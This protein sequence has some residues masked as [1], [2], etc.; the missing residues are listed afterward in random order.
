MD[1]FFKQN[2]RALKSIVV[3]PI[4][5]LH[6]VTAMVRAATKNPS[7]Q[8]PSVEVYFELF[9]LKPIPYAKKKKKTKLTRKFHAADMLMI[10]AAAP[11]QPVDNLVSTTVVDL[12]SLPALGKRQKKRSPSIRRC[13]H[14]LVG[15]M[16]IR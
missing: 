3:S 8:Q 14:S 13:V 6:S 4:E 11:T 7:Y 1:P 10:E 12:V 9:C 15:L 2:L 16:N 5:S